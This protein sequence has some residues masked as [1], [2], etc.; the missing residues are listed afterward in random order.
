[1]KV[2]TLNMTLVLWSS[3]RCVSFAL[4]TLL[5]VCLGTA[6]YGEKEQILS[7][8]SQFRGRRLGRVAQNKKRQEK[9]SNIN[10][11]VYY[12]YNKVYK[13]FV[14]LFSKIIDNMWIIYQIHDIM[15]NIYLQN[16]HWISQNLDI[17]KSDARV[18]ISLD[19][20]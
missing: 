17:K 12:L 16:M 15:I 9:G 13:F 7:W 1:M 5:P 3:L 2:D 10:H 20:T 14:L 8:V 6:G 18:H 19:W 11:V 4:L